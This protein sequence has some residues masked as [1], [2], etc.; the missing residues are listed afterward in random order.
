MLSSAP[1]TSKDHHNAAEREMASGP[2]TTPRK[3]LCSSL[4]V[5]LVVV[6]MNLSQERGRGPA[7]D[8]ERERLLVPGDHNGRGVA[9]WIHCCSQDVARGAPPETEGGKKGLEREGAM[10]AGTSRRGSERVPG[11]GLLESEKEQHRRATS[12]RDRLRPTAWARA[13]S[14]KQELYLSS[15]KLENYEY[16]NGRC[17]AEGLSGITANVG[18]ERQ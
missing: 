12:N 17:A 11:D 2:S 14:R 8:R 4:L 10:M 3:K 7:R 16:A 1:G 9:A 15:R 5:E 6:E 18:D 13:R